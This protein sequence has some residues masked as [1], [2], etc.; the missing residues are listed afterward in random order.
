MIPHLVKKFTRWRARREDATVERL[1]E[2]A[3]CLAEP[4]D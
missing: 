4:T 1:R 2:L 3:H